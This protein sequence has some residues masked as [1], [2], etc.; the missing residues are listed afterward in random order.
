MRD[1]NNTISRV[2]WDYDFSEKELKD[3]LYGKITRLGFLDRDKLIIRMITYL[4]WYEFIQLVPF[5]LF[6][7]IIDDKIIKKIKDNNIA[8]GLKFV[9][10]FLH[11]QTIPASK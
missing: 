11:E 10:R 3:L 8:K 9:N 6:Q 2:F 7:Q 5:N 1:N 4:N